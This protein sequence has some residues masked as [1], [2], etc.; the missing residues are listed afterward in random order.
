MGMCNL[1]I[2]LQAF[3]EHMRVVKPGGWIELTEVHKYLMELRGGRLY[4]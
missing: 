3:K 4:H 1:T 2:S